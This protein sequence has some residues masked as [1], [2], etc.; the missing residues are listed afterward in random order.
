MDLFAFKR[1]R[2]L[3]NTPN[4]R[5]LY[6]SLQFGFG[7]LETRGSG[8]TPDVGV[9]HASHGHVSYIHDVEGVVQFSAAVDPG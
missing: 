2:A 4:I 3:Q 7:D 6:R 1:D 9:K 8:D 5:E